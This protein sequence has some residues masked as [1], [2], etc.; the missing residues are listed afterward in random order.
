MPLKREGGIYWDKESADPS[1]RNRYLHKSQT[2]IGHGQIR[3]SG[4]DRSV[5]RPSSIG[6]GNRC[7]RIKGSVHS[8]ILTPSIGPSLHRPSTHALQKMQQTHVCQSQR[9]FS[10][11]TQPSMQ[12]TVGGG[13]GGGSGYS[14]R[15]DGNLLYSYL[16]IPQ[17]RE[18]A[19]TRHPSR[20]HKGSAMEVNHQSCTTGMYV[21]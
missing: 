2:S 11:Y 7:L 1:K 10:S 15:V 16:P 13:G 6:I 8:A 12:Y 19:E 20:T 14:Q 3:P 21:A 4:T 9:T 18:P 17:Y 5:H